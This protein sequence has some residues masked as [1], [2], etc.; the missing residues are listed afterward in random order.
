MKTKH[1][2]VLLL[3]LALS[4]PTAFGSESKSETK[5]A[6]NSAKVENKLSAEEVSSLTKRV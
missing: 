6:A 4:V 3:V 2:F 5:N 1:F